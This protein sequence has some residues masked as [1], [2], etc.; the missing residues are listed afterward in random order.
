MKKN[1]ENEKEKL[2]KMNVSTSSLIKPHKK[3][4]FFNNK[5]YFK[6]NSFI[7][8][9]III[10]FLFFISYFLYF[11]SL[12]KCFDGE[13]GC[14]IKIHWII[15]KLIE[16]IISCLL[17]SF[18]L[19]LIFVSKIS[20]LHL[21]HLIIAFLYF[22]NYSH[23]LEFSDHGYFNFI[24]FLYLLMII[25]ILSF[26]FKIIFFLLLKFKHI[27]IITFL[28]ILFFFIIG[29]T[30]INPINC[31]DWPKGLNNS[32][33]E[34][35]INKYGC[36]IHIPKECPYKIGKYFQDITKIKNI[37]CIDRKINAKSTIL[38]L[39][40]SPFLN[41]YTKRFGLPQTNKDPIC[42]LDFKDDI[43]LKEYFLN[44]II[45]MDN[46]TENENKTKKEFREII[47]DFSKNYF[48]EMIINL[49]FN[50]TLSEERKTLE[51]L[52][53]PYSNNILLLYF[54][55]VSRAN[56]MRQLRKTLHF[57]ELFISYNGGYNKKFPT[58]TFHSFQFFKY[59]SFKEHTRGNFPRLFYG[60]KRETKNII[61]I[62]KYLK[63]NGFITSFACDICQ[64][65]NTRTLHNLT[66]EESYDHQMLICDPNKE[67]FNKNS[68]KCLYGKLNIEHLYEYT[69]QFWRKYK[70]NRKYSLILS[71]DAHEGTLESLKYM[72]NIVF[73]FLNSLFNN[74]L[75]KDTSI[76]LLSDHGVG[77]PSIYFLYDFYKYEE[78]LPMLYLI[79]NDRKNI[80]YNKQYS[81]IYQN[82]QTFITAY[83]I[84]NT[85]G[86]L[87]YG[88]KYFSINNKSDN[89]DSPK[90]KLGKSLFTE[91]NPKERKSKIYESMQYYV[92][93]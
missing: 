2:F 15:K 57:F 60:N 5:K 51:N 64:R 12:E 3:F 38:R 58:E 30:I 65:D 45:D 44:N 29:F 18:L 28:I 25:Q 4:L 11:L 86:H 52:V 22:Y 83:D 81:F 78:Q 36:Q 9:N 79:I 59:H 89:F 70:N 6:L 42:L 20:K 77:M 13:D 24:G 71:N 54:D 72:D 17:I 85:I 56:S 62:T 68:I 26:I 31:D 14:C 40:K 82:Q 37:K 63:E 16:L 46:I 10:L 21:I 33:I 41:K 8:N 75:L 34:N 74:N 32:Y 80:T 50:K 23:G 43:L 7:K 67:N 48:G 27:F 61:R 84:Y 1:F 66:S 35:D 69:N 47:I 91:I 88:D 19:Q 49:H 92:C 53:A 73:N 90:S 55:S 93:E 76:F 87:I 39:S